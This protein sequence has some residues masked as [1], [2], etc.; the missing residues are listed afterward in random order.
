MRLLR[1]VLFLPAFLP[2]ALAVLL[3]LSGCANTG[4]LGQTDQPAA[5][6]EVFLRLAGPVDENSYY[7]VA[8][9]ASPDS[10][11]AFPVPVAAGPY[12]G[13]GWGTGGISHYVSYHLGQYNLY[14]TQLNALLGAHS[15]GLLNIQGVAVGSEGGLYNLTVQ[16]VNLGAVTVSGAGRIAAVTND[17]DQNAGVLTLTT[18]A[19][20]QVV[21][22]SVSFTPA[23]NGG[24]SLRPTEQAALDALN[25]GGV[26]LQPDSLAALGLTL[27]L[28]PGAGA[29]TLTVAPTVAQVRAVFTSASTKQTTTSVGTV[30]ANS[31]TPT[32]TPPIPGLI[33]V[34]GD[35]AV[36]DTATVSVEFAP[37]GILLSPRLFEYTAPAGGNTLHFTLDLAALGDNLTNLS[38]NFITTTQLIFD[39]TVTDPRQHVYDGLG[40]LG[41]DAVRR[42]DP[43]Q[44]LTV[45]NADAFVREGS[46]DA[47]LEGPATQAQKNAVDIVDWSLSVRRLR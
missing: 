3:G 9:N 47:T 27:A 13:N 44:F 33:L 36:G 15:G 10:A 21:A 24:R 2:C 38:F 41:N 42:F 37:A 20:G 14:R 29:Q 45:T 43:R 30:T 4:S 5:V 31:T 12:W 39:P 6:I 18:D 1:P 34:T 19:G 8:F 23:A 7:F 28:G 35:L 26:T 40:P 46:G 11:N 22:G 32:T 25:A 16:A 17:S